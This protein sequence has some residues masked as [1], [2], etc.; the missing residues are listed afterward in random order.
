MSFTIDLADDDAPRNRQRHCRLSR[1][2]LRLT[3]RSD[4]LLKEIEEGAR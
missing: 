3:K 4:R 1:T 2:L